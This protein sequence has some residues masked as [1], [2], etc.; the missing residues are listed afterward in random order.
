MGRVRS[1][2]PIFSVSLREL[3]KSYRYNFKMVPV[4]MLLQIEIDSPLLDLTFTRNIFHPQTY[5]K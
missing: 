4:Q 1:T 3:R 2:R 5:K